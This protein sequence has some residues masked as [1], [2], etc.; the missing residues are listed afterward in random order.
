MP[1]AAGFD[2]ANYCLRTIST[3][4]MTFLESVGIWI[5]KVVN[6][7]DASCH[8][9]QRLTLKGGCDERRD[10]AGRAYASAENLSTPQLQREKEAEVI[11]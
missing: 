10:E 1:T 6:L 7:M 2:Y 4:L 9:S 3:S 11:R 5:A 8:D